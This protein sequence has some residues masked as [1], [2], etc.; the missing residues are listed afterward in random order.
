M[1]DMSLFE[2]LSP[3][4]KLENMVLMVKG[5]LEDQEEPDLTK[6]CNVVATINA[7]LDQ[8]N[9]CGFY[10]MKEGVLVLG[11]FQGM[12]ACTRIE[13]GKGVCG[14]AAQRRE[15]IIVHDV[16]QFPGH[17]ACDASSNSE[18]VIPILKDEK[19]QGVLDI[20]SMIFSRFSALEKD[21]LE[22]LVQVLSHTINWESIFR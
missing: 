15:T 22:Q 5:L 19:V 1:F 9:W 12:P 18:I 2:A 16:H 17:I 21:Y 7:F 10:I 8:I 14:T 11:P 4:E 3:K 20:D 6:L 13:I